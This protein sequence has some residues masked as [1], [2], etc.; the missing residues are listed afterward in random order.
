MKKKATRLC[1]ILLKKEKTM[2]EKDIRFQ[3]AKIS[4]LG[5]CHKN[6]KQVP[7]FAEG[8]R[9]ENLSA[10]LTL[11]YSW[12]IEKNVFGIQIELKFA[13]ERSA[14]EK[15]DLLTHTCVTDFMVNDLSSILKIKDNNDFTMEEKWEITFVSLAI[16]TARGMMAS[17]TAGTFYEK[18]IFPVID[19]SKVMLSKRLKQN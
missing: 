10:G 14:N 3:I 9:P 1:C 6:H 15:L 8:N 2:S 7:E 5:F 11:N 4:E 12:N 18:F 13:L 16:S 19:P 17:R